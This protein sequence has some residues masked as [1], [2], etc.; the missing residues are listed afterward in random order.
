V[1]HEY[2]SKKRP[3]FIWKFIA[4]LVRIGFRSFGCLPVKKGGDKPLG[5]RLSAPIRVLSK[6][7]PHTIAIYV[8][9]RMSD[10]EIIQTVKPGCSYMGLTTG[11]VVLPIVVLGTLGG[12]RRSAYEIAVGDFIELPHIEDPSRETVE[13]W[14]EK[15]RQGIA[16]IQERHQ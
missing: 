4:I 16:A 13:H 15:I 3:R 10:D 6:S 11:A 7:D 5:E 9:G 12:K 8:E 14:N 2:F 1:K